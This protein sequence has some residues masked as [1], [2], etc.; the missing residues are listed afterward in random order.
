MASYSHFYLSIE[1]V[2]SQL[3]KESIATKLINLST[4]TSTTEQT[5]E[6]IIATALN[7]LSTLHKNQLG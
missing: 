2:C 6:E 5:F 4:S 3:H 7:N 1:T